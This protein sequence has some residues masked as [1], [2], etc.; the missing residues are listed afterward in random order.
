[1]M[2]LA[3]LNSKVY[4]A[5]LLLADYMLYCVISVLI[6]VVCL[7]W[8]LRPFNAN[9]AAFVVNIF[10]SGLPII[11][12]SY[13]VASFFSDQSRASRWNI[14]FQMII[15]TLVPVFLCTV[16][17]DAPVGF[18][19]IVVF[20]FYLVNPLFTQYFTNFV[21]TLDFVREYT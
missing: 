10:A 1:M 8:G 17:A 15:G 19:N 6:T 9:T 4:Y 2:R 7:S 13:V 20:L 11:C 12:L 21:F 18:L 14:I 3:G 5:G 16:I